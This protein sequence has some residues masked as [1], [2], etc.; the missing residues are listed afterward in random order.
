MKR[1]N[2]LALSRSAPALFQR[3]LQR[4]MLAAHPEADRL[5][6]PERARDRHDLS[7]EIPI[8][9]APDSARPMTICAEP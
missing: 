8:H 7:E 9:G 6:P 5:T 3:R 4:A 2:G 1:A